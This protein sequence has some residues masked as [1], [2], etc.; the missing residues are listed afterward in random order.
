MKRQNRLKIDSLLKVLPN[1]RDSARVD[2]L[3]ALFLPYKR[4]GKKDSSLYYITK[5]HEEAREINYIN[6][7]ADALTNK[8]YTEIFFNANYPG[9]EKLAREA[10]SWYKKTPNKKGIGWV[11]YNLGESLCYQCFFSEANKNF[12]QAFYWYKKTGNELGMFSTLTSWGC[13]YEESGDY[14]NAFECY[15]QGLELAKKTNNDLWLRDGL[16]HMG[17]LYRQIEDYP[18]AI[19][20]FRQALQKTNP[21]ERHGF[22]MEFA[23]LFSLQHQY[24]SALY[25][26]NQLDTANSDELALH[27][28]YHT[29]KGEYFLF[30]KE[31][32][33]ALQYFQSAL[34]YYKK[35]NDRNG[36]TRTL[37]DIAKTHLALQN[38]DSALHYA[39]QGLSLARQASSN[40]YIRDGLNT[41]YSVYEHRKQFDSAYFYYRQYNIL[42]DSIL[43]DQ[44]KARFAIYGPELKIELLNKEKEIQQAK[45]QKEA[46][47]KKMLIGGILLLLLLSVFIFW[48]IMLKRKN[49]LQLQKLEMERT[50]AEFQQ[51]AT[52]LEMQALRAQMSPHFIFNSLNSIN[53]FI[54]QNN[55][56]QAS[57]Y[58]TKFSKLVRLIL[59]NS[60]AALIPLESELESLQLYLELE[61]IRFEH[62]FDYKIIVEDELDVSVLKVPPLIIQPYAENA[63]WHGLMHKEEKGNLEIELFQEDDVLFCKITDDG[64]GRKKAVELKSKS[65]S[66]YKSMGMR[67]SADRIALLQ[68]KKEADSYIIITDLVLPDGKSGGTEVVLKI[69]VI[70]D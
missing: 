58:L 25:Y 5:A 8:A 23:E 15:R 24:D 20:Y 57:E 33:K 13:N 28:G 30:Q 1:L 68:Q 34:N 3:N 66:T 11:Y 67:I 49:E 65:A 52:E 70:Y 44:V 6:G 9:G 41:L 47:L 31:Y 16:K 12:K 46:I 26:F 45:L 60:R 29:V 32:G 61:A 54:L 64:I 42:N 53:R 63:I 36:A 22:Y 69:P 27:H 51:Q 56:A 39:R 55:K 14:E 18:T 17:V 35:R 37:L 50:K 2:C 19:N 38:N 48:Y 7:I 43:N 4:I 40:K 10:L 21:Q 62:H 59:Q